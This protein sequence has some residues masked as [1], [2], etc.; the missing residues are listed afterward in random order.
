M[1]NNTYKKKM[2]A[3]LEGLQIERI[4]EFMDNAKTGDYRLLGVKY[5][6]AVKNKMKEK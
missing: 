4:D 5:V 2:R 6:E 3:L 1:F